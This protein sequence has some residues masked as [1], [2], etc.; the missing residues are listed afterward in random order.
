MKLLY[1]QIKVY[2]RKTQVLCL[3][4]CCCVGRGTPATQRETKP[5]TR[6]SVKRK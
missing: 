1:L 3:D 6:D 5:D 2:Y 4:Y